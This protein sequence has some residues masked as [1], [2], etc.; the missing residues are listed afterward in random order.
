LLVTKFPNLI[1]DAC[2]AFFYKPLPGIDTFYSPR[3]FFGVSDGGYVS[4]D[5]TLKDTFTHDSSF[6]RFSHLL[7]R[8]DKGAEKGY[9]NFKANEDAL[10]DLPIRLMSKL[11]TTLMNGIDYQNS[12]N[13]RNENFSFLHSK[14]K[15]QNGFTWIKEDLINGPMIYPFYTTQ[16][17]LREK[18]I[19][20]KIYLAQYWPNI[21][22]WVNK[23]SNEFKYYENIL[24]LPI[25]QRYGKEEM[26]II[27]GIING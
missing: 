15:K 26:K 5:K 6:N 1:I 8:I 24:T 17:N 23:E 10:A 9:S 16:K 22:D 4:C 13:K 18:F 27:I 7:I 12:L 3:K 20:H 2:Q 25:D 11:T 21:V 14:L 19:N